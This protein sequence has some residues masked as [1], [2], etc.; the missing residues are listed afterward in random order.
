MS[1]RIL[2]YDIIENPLS[3]GQSY[4]GVIHHQQ[5]LNNEALISE[6]VSRNSTVT[7]QEALAVIDLY[8]E[9]IKQNLAKGNTI[10]TGLFRA[11][12]SMSGQF[13]SMTDKIDYRK[14]KARV[15]IRPAIKLNKEICRNLRFHKRRQTRNNTFISYIS[16]MG[17]KLAPG[18]ISAG[19]VFVIRGKGFKYYKHENSYELSLKQYRGKSHTL[20]VL[21]A[22]FGKITAIIPT[23]FAP[24]DYELQLVH[25]YGSVERKFPRRQITVV[26]A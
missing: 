10:T 7:R 16:E 6:L 26:K 12:I 20:R 5:V 2:E 1:D 13:E 22:T 11:D 23:E 21:S 14:H 15:V 4:R 8:E 25:R 24:G 18:T 3:K 19:G 9:V 17:S